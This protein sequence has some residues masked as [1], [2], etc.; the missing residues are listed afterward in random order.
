MPSTMPRVEGSSVLRM[1]SSE[2][3]SPH[4]FGGLGAA[5]D[6]FDTSMRSNMPPEVDVSGGGGPYFVFMSAAG[7]EA[8]GATFLRSAAMA[9][10]TSSKAPMGHLSR[11]LARAI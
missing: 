7:A 8:P 2:S 4:V 10:S 9:A 1:F 3:V 11:R 6:G 5:I